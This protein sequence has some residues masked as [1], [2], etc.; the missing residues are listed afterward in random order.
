MISADVKAD[1][2][3]K[4]LINKELVVVCCLQLQFCLEPFGQHC[5]GFDLCNVVSGY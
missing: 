4:T 1:V 2:K 5:T 3:S